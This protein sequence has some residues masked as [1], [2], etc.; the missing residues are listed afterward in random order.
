MYKIASVTPTSDETKNFQRISWSHNE[1]RLAAVTGDPLPC[2]HMICRGPV[3]QQR[4]NTTP[5]PV[6]P[7]RAALTAIQLPGLCSTRCLTPM[8]RQW[9]HMFEPQCRRIYSRSYPWF[10]TLQSHSQH[11]NAVFA[12][13]HTHIQPQ[14]RMHQSICTAALIRK[15]TGIYLNDRH[16]HVMPIDALIQ[17]MP[18]IQRIP[19]E[20]GSVQPRY[21]IDSHLL[22]QLG[23]FFDSTIEV[24]VRWVRPSL[25]HGIPG[26]A[27]QVERCPINEDLLS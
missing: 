19:E 20:H 9:A 12:I 26:D 5:S 23:I 11:E 22:H 8:C 1:E 17:P 6:T 25:W 2:C 27:L 14:T 7:T 10:S 16:V 3:A 4:R 21:R 13:L 24:Q 15:Y 18:K